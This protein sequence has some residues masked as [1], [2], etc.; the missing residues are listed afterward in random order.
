MKEF[1]RQFYY[2]C[3]NNSFTNIHVILLLSE[4]NLASLQ[5]SRLNCEECAWMMSPFM[6]GNE[7]VWTVKKTLRKKIESPKFLFLLGY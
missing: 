2:D 7:D 6:G 4:R 5:E 1:V 3:K